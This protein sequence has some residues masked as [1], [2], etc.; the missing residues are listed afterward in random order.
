MRPRPL[1]F[2]L[3]AAAAVLSCK[4]ATTSTLETAPPS[5]AVASD[6]VAS[7]GSRGTQ[8]VE[9][10]PPPEPGAWATTIGPA[11]V[12]QAQ[13]VVVD[14]EGTTHV[15]TPMVRKCND[16]S[17]T[18]GSLLGGEPT[19]IAHDRHGRLL[20]VRPLELP[21]NFV[22]AMTTTA[23]G[24][25]AL[26]SQPDHSAADVRPRIRLLD[27]ANGRVAETLV[28]ELEADPGPSHLACTRDGG[29][30][31]AGVFAGSLRIGPDSLRSSSEEWDVFVARFDASGQPR[32]HVTARG[33]TPKLSGQDTLRAMELLSD[34]D[35]AITG[36]CRGQ[37][38][39]FTAGE[40]S[41][42]IRCGG[43]RRDDAYVARIGSDGTLRW[44]RHLWSTSSGSKWIGIGAVPV[45]MAEAPDRGLVVAG[46]FSHV[47]ELRS[48]DATRSLHGRGFSDTF[49]ARYDAAGTLVDAWQIGGPGQ[50]RVG[51]MV[52]VGDDLWLAGTVA[53]EDALT[54][55]RPSR[56]FEDHRPEGLGLPMVGV[57]LRMGLTD[58][59]HD[60]VVLRGEADVLF[61]VQ[62]E[63]LLAA[64]DGLRMA[65]S[66]IGEAASFPF[67]DGT[68]TVLLRRVPPEATYESFLW[69]PPWEALRPGTLLP[70]R[71]A[72]VTRGTTT[73]EP[74]FR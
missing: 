28:L 51:D 60:H 16:P 8:P 32:W 39:R 71:R 26:L 30:V 2:S 68:A 64:P 18:C 6:A 44:V 41:E 34:G 57:L 13:H 49:V 31:V 55:L 65:G 48:G 74:S 25:L 69:A 63:Q 3:A 1:V 19:L 56:K 43:R 42:S 24:K 27:P 33:H 54:E 50:D 67:G 11:G 53:G 38:L 9:P 37:P 20:H 21:E 47:L 7:D 45:A 22:D 66:F 46:L 62:P 72:P 5:G 35:V 14:T 23:D 12:Q 52:V 17:G 73:T 4:P 15:V 70:L 29:F 61:S 10:A 40:R 36:G 58:G 59:S